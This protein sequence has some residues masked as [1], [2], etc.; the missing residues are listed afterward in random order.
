MVQE[1][2]K[3]K[4]IKFTGEIWKAKQED[5]RK[6]EIPIWTVGSEELT[7]TEAWRLPRINI[8]RDELDQAGRGWKNQIQIG[9]L[10]IF[11]FFGRPFWN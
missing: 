3:W 2:V 4:H 9:K 8:R 7:S 6:D 5:Q 11:N 1:I 10:H